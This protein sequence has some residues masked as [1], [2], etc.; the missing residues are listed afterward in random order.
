MELSIKHSPSSEIV[1]DLYA[2]FVTSNHVPVLQIRRG[3]RD[4]LEINSHI[5]P[6]KHIL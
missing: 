3:N 1:I 4:N 5:Y 6:Y 2:V